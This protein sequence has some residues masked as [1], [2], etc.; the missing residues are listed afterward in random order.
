MLL[1]WGIKSYHM[2]TALVWST[3]TTTV[4][5]VF[6]NTTKKDYDIL[7]SQ[8]YS[9]SKRLEDYNSASKQFFTSYLREVNYETGYTTNYPDEIDVVLS[10]IS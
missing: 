4:L 7:V 2:H 8:L 3:K 9:L 6:T 5:V 10:K 1:E